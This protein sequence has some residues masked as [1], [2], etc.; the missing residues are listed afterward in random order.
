MNEEFTTPPETPPATP[1]TPPTIVPEDLRKVDVTIGYYQTRRGVILPALLFDHSTDKVLLTTKT[2]RQLARQ[3]SD[4]AS[5]LEKR[6]E[7]RNKNARNARRRK[8]K[9]SSQSRERNRR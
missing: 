8:R 2:A 7:R 6:D 5:E 9:I 4:L 3:I 1:P